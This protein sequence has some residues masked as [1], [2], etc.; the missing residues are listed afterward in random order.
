MNCA[1]TVPKICQEYQNICK[2]IERYRNPRELKIQLSTEVSPYIFLFPLFLCLL[3]TVE[4]GGSN[5]LSPTTLFSTTCVI[6]GA[7]K[8]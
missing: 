2:N 8:S 5:P 3:H 1:Q 4:A 6:S 7:T